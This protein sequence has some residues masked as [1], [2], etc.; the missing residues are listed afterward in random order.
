[1]EW[2]SQKKNDWHQPAESGSGPA[3]VMEPVAIA[4]VSIPDAAGT[5]HE[6]APETRKKNFSM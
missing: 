3:D 1:M 6:D 5:S 4:G 2:A